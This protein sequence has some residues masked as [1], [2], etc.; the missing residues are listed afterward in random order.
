MH[1]V[2]RSDQH[3]APPSEPCPRQIGGARIVVGRNPV[4]RR[5][6]IGVRAGVDDEAIGQRTQVSVGEASWSLARPP[7]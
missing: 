3:R 6:R 2:Q 7:K 5:N 4:H 1:L